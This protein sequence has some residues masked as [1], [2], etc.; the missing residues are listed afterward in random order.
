M[1]AGGRQLGYSQNG[2]SRRGC[3]E[4]LNAEMDPVK[5]EVGRVVGAAAVAATRPEDEGLARR[6]G[7]LAAFLP[8]GQRTLADKHQF[9]GINHV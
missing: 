5:F 9:V 8:H 2:L 7:E 4:I 6:E 1:R 3:W